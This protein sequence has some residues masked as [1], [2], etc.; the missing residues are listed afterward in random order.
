MN[1]ENE[2][3]KRQCPKNGQ[4]SAECITC[5][6]LIICNEIKDQE[7]SDWRKFRIGK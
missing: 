3:C 6:N 5:N 7:A 4:S 1:R 2:D